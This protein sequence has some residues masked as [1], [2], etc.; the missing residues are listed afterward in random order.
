[1]SKETDELK[2]ELS[3]QAVSTSIDPNDLL[4][5]G[6]TLLNLACTGQRDVLPVGW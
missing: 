4:S 6:S 3:R 5:T 2:A 1:M